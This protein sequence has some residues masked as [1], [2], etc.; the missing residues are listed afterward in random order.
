M[1][2]KE[3][4]TAITQ[5]SVKDLAEL[6]GWLENY[7]AQLWDKQIEADLEAGRLDA[8]LAEVDK[9]YEEGCRGIAL[10]NA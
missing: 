3:I 8:L 10:C 5:L 1:S 6:M 2:V 4:E 7:Q 9:E